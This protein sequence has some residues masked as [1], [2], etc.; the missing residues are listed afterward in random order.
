M[1]VLLWRVI[2]GFVR[3]PVDRPL[4]RWVIVQAEQA[5]ET[6][7]AGAGEPAGADEFVADDPGA[8]ED[9]SAGETRDRE[10]VA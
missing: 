4:H 3:R 5:D 6:A 1:L 7:L 8:G 10:P 9:V 2:D